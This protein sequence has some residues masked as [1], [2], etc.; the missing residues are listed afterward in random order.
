MSR[1]PDGLVDYVRAN[2][3]QKDPVEL[4]AGIKKKFGIDMNPK[5]VRAMK[6]RYKLSGGHVQ[7]YIQAHSPKR[8][9]IISNLIMWVP[10]QQK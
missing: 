4:A 7:K 5:A 1:Y 8:C 10:G 3:M 2:Y 9:V 6:K